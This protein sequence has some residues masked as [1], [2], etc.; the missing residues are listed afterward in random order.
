MYTFKFDKK[1]PNGI[2]IYKDF[3]LI[4][5]VAIPPGR[6]GC[7]IID[8]DEKDMGKYKMDF[9]GLVIFSDFKTRRMYHEGILVD[10]IDK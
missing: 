7:D 10:I 4:N 5:M 8:F 2:L 3:K 1:N 6:T 9:D